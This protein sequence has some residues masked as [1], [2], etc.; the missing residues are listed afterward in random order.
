MIQPSPS[1]VLANA[2]G[3]SRWVYGQNVEYAPGVSVSTVAP[4][5]SYAC[6]PS[7]GLVGTDCTAFGSFSANYTGP[8]FGASGYMVKDQ[9]NVVG[10][11]V[12]GMAVEVVTEVGTMS[13]YKLDGIIGMGFMSQNQG[14]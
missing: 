7:S 6:D 4:H 1:D 10:E 12:R 3:F 14:I 9:V 11:V 8:G 13:G 5:T 2:T